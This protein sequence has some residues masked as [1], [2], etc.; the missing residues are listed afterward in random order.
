MSQWT[1]FDKDGNFGDA[2]DLIFVDTSNFSESEWFELQCVGEVHD[3]A[4]AIAKSRNASVFSI[5]YEEG[6]GSCNTL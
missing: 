5:S 2:E 6:M 3:A 4:I 1:Y